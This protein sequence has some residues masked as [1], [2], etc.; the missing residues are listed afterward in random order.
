MSTGPSARHGHKM[1]YLPVLNALIIIGGIIFT[2]VTFI[3]RN[4]F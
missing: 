4:D 3:G 2:R 1:E